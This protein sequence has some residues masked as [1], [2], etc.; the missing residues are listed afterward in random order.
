[1][2]TIFGNLFCMVRQC[3]FSVLSF[4]PMPNHIAF[5]MD[6][7]RRYAKNRNMEQGSGHGAGF[8]TLKSILRYCF[9]MGV[10]Y[11]TIYA[12]S[13]DNFKRK[14]EEVQSTMDLMNEKID[15]LLK[16]Q[17][18]V[19]EYEVRMN[20]WG[21]LD[22][23]ND[24][25]RFSAEKAMKNTFHNTGPVLSVCVA[26]TSTNEIA[27]AIQESCYEKR[28]MVTQ[29]HVYGRKND[30]FKEFDMKSII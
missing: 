4:G 29:T 7:N 1:M 15:E 28:N 5:I 3:I 9:E 13:I 11:V 27:H 17:S 22:L 19:N 10:K 23:L 20:F 12:F 30:F 6:G 24:S 2:S 21:N 26:Y 8:S 14:P 16:E 18:I 25:V